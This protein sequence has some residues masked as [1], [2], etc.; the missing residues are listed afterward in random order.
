MGTTKWLVPPGARQM[1]VAEGMD[2]GGG[3]DALGEGI[4]SIFCE[5][6]LG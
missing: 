5:S 4:F 1:P 3:L 6:N 2:R